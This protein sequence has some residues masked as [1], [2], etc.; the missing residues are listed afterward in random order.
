MSKQKNALDIDS[1]KL[2]AL[3]KRLDSDLAI[4]VIFSGLSLSTEKIFDTIETVCHVMAI[5]SKTNISDIVFDTK[6]TM[7]EK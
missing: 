4:Q 1:K 3:L 5:R 7:N 2:D 6:K